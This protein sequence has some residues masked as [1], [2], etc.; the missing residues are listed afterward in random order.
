M[1]VEDYPEKKKEGSSSRGLIRDRDKGSC[2][3]RHV[4]C[5]LRRECNINKG[6]TTGIDCSEP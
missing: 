1:I 5:M 2:T 6:A 4:Q 3:A